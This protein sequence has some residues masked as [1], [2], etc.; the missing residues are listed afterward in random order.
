M[1]NL[2]ILNI[3][4]TKMI[5]LFGFANVSGVTTSACSLNTGIRLHFSA[6]N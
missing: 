1:D 3:V 5:K 6:K 4:I 2:C